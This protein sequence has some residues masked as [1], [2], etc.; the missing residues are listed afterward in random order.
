MNSVEIGTRNIKIALKRL[1]RWVREGAQ[2]EVR[3]PRN[4]PID[5]R[6]RL[7]RRQDPAGAAQCGQAPDGSST[8]AGSMDDT[9]SSVVQELFFR[10][11]H[12]VSGRWS[13]STST[14]ASTKA[15]G[16]TTVV[17]IP[18]SSRLSTCWHKYGSDYKAVFVGDA[19]MSPYEI[20]YP[21]GAVE[22]WNKEAGSVWL[23]RVLEQWPN[24]VWINPVPE[25]ELG[26]HAL[27]PDD[28]RP[29][30]RTHVPLE[31]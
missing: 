19:S 24:A 16:R 4:H 27:D 23:Q 17:G 14:T 18:K 30:S 20:A 13:I 22:H 10:R 26:L 5:R 28:P 8:S 31:R 25:K 29:L 21:G 15:C 11:P 7:S 3:S 9:Q 1:R 6:T 2:E 12:R